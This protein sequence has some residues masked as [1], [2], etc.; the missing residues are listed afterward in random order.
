LLAYGKYGIYGGDYN[1]DGKIDLTDRE[2]I[3]DAYL[4]T[5]K[6]YLRLDING[7]G[8][9]DLSDREIINDAYLKTITANKPN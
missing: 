1:W 7:D 2:A 6:G 8:V 3:N 4:V 5:T 9:I